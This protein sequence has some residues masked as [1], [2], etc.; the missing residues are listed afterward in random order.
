MNVTVR[1]EGRVGGH[2][3][4]ERER[5]RERE[6]EKPKR[7]CIGTKVKRKTLKG[8]HILVVFHNMDLLSVPAK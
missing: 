8:A 7:R 2:S 4:Q 3:V 1:M 6:R 5:E